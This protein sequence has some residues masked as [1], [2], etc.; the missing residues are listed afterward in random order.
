MCGSIATTETFSF[1][2]YSKARS[3]TSLWGLMVAKAPFDGK[4][5]QGE[6]TKIN[7]ANHESGLV[8]P[9]LSSPTS[10]ATAFA[11][12]ALVCLPIARQSR[13]HW[14]PLALKTSFQSTLH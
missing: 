9:L 11:P 10:V 4:Q 5:R 13:R 7:L 1:S 8:L 6:Q 3:I 14:W 12:R 2:V